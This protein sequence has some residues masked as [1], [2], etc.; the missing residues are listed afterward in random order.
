M[1]PSSS[2]LPF[3]VRRKDPE[4][5]VPAKPIPYD[6]KQ[7]SDVDNQEA[8][9]YQISFIMFYDSNSNPCMEGE[10]PVKSIR[11]ALAEALV[12][13][14]PFAG[15][16]KEG[17]DG[18]LLVDCTG[19][20]VLFIEAD[21]DT[22][23]EL[24]EDTIQP[25]VP[26]LDRLLYEVP[27]S[28]GIVG[29]PLLLIQ[30]TRLMCGG[31]VFAIRW[32][33]TIAD[34]V[35]MFKFLNTVAEMVPSGAAKPSFLPVWQR[36]LLTARDPPRVTY[37]HHEFD[38]VDDTDYGTVDDD[39]IVHKSFLF[40]PKEMSSLRDLLPPHL[41]SS[42]SFL[43][44]SACL[45]KCRT[46]AMQLEPDEIVRVSYMVSAGGKEGIKLPAGYYG[47]AVTFPVALSKA[48]LLC[49]NPLEYGLDLVKE[50]K[51]RLNE[52]YIR[53]AID[54][55]V[56]KGRKQYRT[57]RDF[58]IADT[59]RVPFG[60]IDL[61]WG[62]PVYGGPAGAIK[63][64][65]FFAKFKNGKGEDGIVVQVSLP[66]QIMERFQKELVKMVGDSLNDQHYRIATEITYSKL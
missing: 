52:E 59:T 8:L 45:W 6:Q 5:V 31:F 29:C 46:I 24:L 57:V 4:L 51:N 44:L 12:F 3:A 18:K 30:V 23:L 42:S 61:G 33:H 55:F 25:P 48:G 16:L 65:S 56:I 28:T 41:R 58:V 9:R 20:G 62:K 17:P 53:S 13:Y 34:A 27:G 47:N 7:L 43:V 15:R 49:K 11:A 50:I 40:G 21:A 2:L 39:S 60:D 35:G 1:A 54:L 19:E 14:Y 37:E 22:T 26:Y 32:N 63:D 66:W 38:E 36:E 64:V 10:D